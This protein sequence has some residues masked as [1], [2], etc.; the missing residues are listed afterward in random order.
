ME[1]LNNIKL[2]QKRKT[3]DQLLN[4]SIFNNGLTKYDRKAKAL[5]TDIN[6]AKV[7]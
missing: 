1:A 5:M 3:I 7:D 6:K 4:T 2:D